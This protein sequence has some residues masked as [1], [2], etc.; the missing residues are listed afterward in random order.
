[1]AVFQKFT[2]D[3]IA[4]IPIEALLQS[5]RD[6]GIS[7]EVS[8]AEQ[9]EAEREAVRVLARADGF[10]AGVKHAQ[11][12]REANIETLLDRL[13]EKVAAVNAMI[14]A[15]ADALASEAAALALDFADAIAREAMSQAPRAA[16]AET[17]RAAMKDAV[18]RPKLTV[19]VSADDACEIERLV[20]KERAACGFD[21]RVTVV[22]DKD[23]APGDCEID[24]QTGGLRL[25]Q[26]ERAEAVRRLVAAV[27]ASA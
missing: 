17:L 14:E 23:V 8:I 12:Q 11:A 2:F 22:P 3:D 20:M 1:M 9:L 16:L 10:E 27:S 13:V 21:G 5:E 19:K 6:A 15:Q 26:E 24:W 4:T 25:C 18:V 7:N